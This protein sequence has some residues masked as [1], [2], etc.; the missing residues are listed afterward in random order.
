MVLFKSFRAATAGLVSAAALIG[1]AW[2]AQAE[3]RRAESERFIVYG[4]TRAGALTEFAQKLETF[5]RVLRIFMGLPMAEAPPRK[6]PIYVVRNHAELRTVNP[7][8]GAQ[9]IGFYIPTEEDIFAMAWRQGGADSILLHEYGHHFML[10]HF[11]YGY[12]AWFVEGFA[13]YFAS[14][15]IVGNKVNVGLVDESRAYA[16]FNVR[17]LPMTDLLTKSPTEID[18]RDESYYPLAGILTHWFLSDD[19]RR[20]KLGAYLRD[21]SQGVD[22]IQAL[23]VHMGLTPVELERELRSYIRG[24]VAYK[25]IRADFPDV[26][27]VV[28]ELPASADDLLLLNQRLK[29]QI[30][31]EDRAALLEQVRTAAAPHG[32]PF[33]MKILAHAELKLGERATAESLLRAVLDQTPED[34]EALQLMARLRMDQADD[35]TDF[36]AGDALR[37]QAR[38]FLARAYQL[39]DAN[40]RTFYLLAESRR[41][42]ANYPTENDIE[43]L[44]LA[45]DLAPQ[46]AGARFNL[47]ATLIYAGRKDEGIALLS[48]LVNDPH[49]AS[50]ASAARNMIERAQADPR[51]RQVLDDAEAAEDIEPETTPEP[52]PAP[53]A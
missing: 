39:D 1:G 7:E 20:A 47:A 3:W 34:V 42:A 33:A 43:T 6:L 35:Q 29:L 52:E 11:P 28:T 19:A 21:I 37:G 46:L 14:A 51:S 40:F 53:A 8:L 18:R 50:V 16:L 24:R 9:F 23:E 27:T 5:D 13:E 12:P 32:D 22:P 30:K 26:P 45:Y 48:P 15:D 25:Q 17:W 2:P 49:N 36:E 31:E 44:R 41:T 4:Q 10:Q 38:A